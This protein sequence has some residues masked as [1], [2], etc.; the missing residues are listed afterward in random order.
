MKRSRI[1]PVRRKPRPG[2][3]KGKDMT[4]LRQRVWERDLG[5]CGFCFL[6]CDPEDW[7]LAHRRNKRMYG[8]GDNNVQVAHHSCHMASHNCQGKPCPPKV[9]T[10]N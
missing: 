8:D 4:A 3:A 2:R 1:N 6:P 9:K 5:C 10:C 7:D